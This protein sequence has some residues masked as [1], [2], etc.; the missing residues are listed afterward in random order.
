MR[1]HSQHGFTLIELIVVIA[2]IALLAAILFPVF[3]ST[4]EKARMTSCLSNVHQIA[5]AVQ[6]YAND[7][8]SVCPDATTVWQQLNLDPKLLICPTMGNSMPNGYGYNLS[9]SNRAISDSSIP[10]PSKIVVLAD[11]SIGAQ[12]PAILSYPSDVDFRHNQKNSA[13][14][15]FLD[16]HV[17]ALT[18]CPSLPILTNLDLAASW[19][20]ISAPG[21]AYNATADGPLQNI[22][23]GWTTNQTGTMT[24]WDWDGIGKEYG[25]NSMNNMNLSCTNYYTGEDIVSTPAID[26]WL[27]CSLPGDPQYPDVSTRLAAGQHYHAWTLNLHMMLYNLVNVAGVIDPTQFNCDP[28][29]A[30]QDING[31]NL[32]KIEW[33]V[34]GAATEE[35]V[36]GTVLFNGTAISSCQGLTTPG[37]DLNSALQETMIFPGMSQWGYTGGVFDLQLA[38]FDNGSVSCHISMTQPNTATI[39]GAGSVAA[40]ADVTRPAKLTF[41]CGCGNLPDGGGN[42]LIYQTDAGLV[43]WGYEIAH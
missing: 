21:W 41:Y 31:N 23:P 8:D 1:L 28:Y 33:K 10:A 36:T 42:F 27:A 2:I 6:I 18:S 11:C 32:A 24:L 14:F 9:L 16:G 3:F 19:L 22:Y 43:P 40:G 29:I 4:R 5:M 35:G 7:H 34:T 38:G 37:N 17:L 39:T 30:I 25:I 12:L 26:L 15:G 13:I 20:P